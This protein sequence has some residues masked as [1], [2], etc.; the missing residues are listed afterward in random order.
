MPKDP[1]AYSPK[2][3]NPPEATRAKA[4][5]ASIGEEKASGCILLWLYRDDRIVQ[6]SMLP[7]TEMH[8]GDA[9]I[10]YLLG[11]VPRSGLGWIE[12]S[13]KSPFFQRDGQGFGV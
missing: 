1:R 10:P 13:D 7:E 5:K 12:R 6:A 11:R 9:W 3:P 2:T 8:P 4:I